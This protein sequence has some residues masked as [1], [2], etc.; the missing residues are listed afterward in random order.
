MAMAAA[1]AAAM[2][3]VASAAVTTVVVAT[4]AASTAKPHLRLRQFLPTAELASAAALMLW[5]AS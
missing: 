1:S 3:A 2:A 4:A 5:H